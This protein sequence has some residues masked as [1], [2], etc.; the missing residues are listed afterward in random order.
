[1]NDSALWMALKDFRDAPLRE[2]A[3]QLL[4]KFGLASEYVIDTDGSLGDFL[5]MFDVRQKL[6]GKE[7]QNLRRLV[8]KIVFLFQLTQED[9]SLSPSSGNDGGLLANSII[10]IAADVNCSSYLTQDE[11]QGVIRSLRKGFSDPVVGLFRYGKQMAFTAVAHRQHQIQSEIDVFFGAGATENI[12][13]S[14]PDWRHKDFLLR[15]QRIVASGSTATL[16][17]VVQHLI[18]VPNKYRADKLCQNSD[19]PDILRMYIG[20]VSRWPL[21]TKAE[22]K[23][24]ARRIGHDADAKERFYCS[25]LRLVIWQAK[26]YADVS[27]IDILDLIQEGNIGLRKAVDK[28]EHRRGYKFSTYATWWIRQAITR[29]IAD[30]GRLIRIPVH[31]FEDIRR[32]DR[33]CYTTFRRTGRDATLDE[34]SKK[35]QWSAKKAARVL[36]IVEDPVSMESSTGDDTSISRLNDSIEDENADSLVDMVTRSCIKQA[37]RTVLMSITE[38]ESK[39]LRMRFGIGMKTD[40]TLEE[41]GKQFDVTRERIRQIES[42]ALR[43][44]AQSKHLRTF[45]DN[46]ANCHIHSGLVGCG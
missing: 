14:N 31:A 6:T 29:Y 3:V 22:E 10:F 18:N 43:K 37:I 40:H 45:L 44:L 5:D 32:L 26:R 39:V 7:Y 42:K 16:G 38:R 46:A 13:L 17:E 30:H 34:I 21:L 23:E 1:M 35:L 41:I 24:L 27:N 9:V 28:F 4:G 36:S 8:R 20:D 19:S 33:V 11:L 25:N 12:N 15:W 2:G